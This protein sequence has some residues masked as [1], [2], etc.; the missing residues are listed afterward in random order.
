LY[1][2]VAM[3]QTPTMSESAK[4]STFRNVDAQCWTQMAAPFPGFAIWQLR[5]DWLDALFGGAFPTRHYPLTVLLWRT[6]LRA[7]GLRMGSRAALVSADAG[8]EVARS[9]L[10]GQQANYENQRA[11]LAKARAVAAND[12][13]QAERMKTLFQKGMVAAADWDN[14]RTTADSSAASTDAAE[15]QVRLANVQISTQESQVRLAQA[16]VET[17][18]AALTLARTNL[19]NTRLLA[20]FAG[21]VAQR[22]LDQ[23]AAVSAQSSG[24]TNTSVGIILLQD[25][26]SVKVQLEVPERDIGRVKVGGPVGVTADPY[27]GELFAGSIARVVHNL[28][29]RSRTMGVEV[30][31]P[32]PDTRL[33]PGMFARVE[34]VVETRTGVLSVPMETLRVGEG[35]PLVMVV[36]NGVVETVPVQLGAADAKGIEIVKGLGEREQ[37]IL[38][39]KDLVRQG[40]KVRTT[41]A[42]GQ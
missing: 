42:G 30:E 12:A 28:D 4:W 11:N 7:D 29:P 1:D 36:R 20:P 31:I 14:A 21:Y 38:Q 37:V 9:T 18:R 6:F 33:K 13:R 26:K 41:P 8:L 2:E 32:N 19:A 5:D 25:I 3:L 24:T 17:F 16:Q 34:A 10:E 40:Q 35:P 22:N 27:K 15:A 39:G 23:G